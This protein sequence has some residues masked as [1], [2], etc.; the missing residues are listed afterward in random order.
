MKAA[1]LSVLAMLTLLA[2]LAMAACKNADVAPASKADCAKLRDKYDAL[3]AD[4]AL[5]SLPSEQRSAALEMKAALS[6][7][8]RGYKKVSERC[9]AVTERQAACAMEATTLDAWDTCLR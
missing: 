3:D 9:D 5:A 2:M 8:E 4:P 6:R 7:G 1:A